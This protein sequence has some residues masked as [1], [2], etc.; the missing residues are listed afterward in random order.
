MSRLLSTVWNA[1]YGQHSCLDFILNSETH[2]VM[3]IV[4]A[5]TLGSLTVLAPA[6]L[7]L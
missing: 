6:C 5:T 3:T 1:V 7:Q 2:E 4:S